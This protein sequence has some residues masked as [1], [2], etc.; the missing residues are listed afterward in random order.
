VDKSS[1]L[2]L[3]ITPAELRWQAKPYDL[4]EIYTSTDFVSWA[5]TGECM[6]QA[7]VATMSHL[8]S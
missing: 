8:F 7:P 4:Y 6:V 5:L 3:E 2:R 1:N